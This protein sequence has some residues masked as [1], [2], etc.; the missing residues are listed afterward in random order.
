MQPSAVLSAVRSQFRVL[1]SLLV[2]PR[3]ASPGNDVPQE[4]PA[5]VDPSF[6]DL[7]T[8]LF[9]SEGVLENSHNQLQRMA[10]LADALDYVGLCRLLETVNGPDLAI[11]LCY[12]VVTRLNHS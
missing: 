3:H 12:P 7:S 5:P 4:Q 6:D 1:R 8:P 10:S 2:D 11:H 9:R